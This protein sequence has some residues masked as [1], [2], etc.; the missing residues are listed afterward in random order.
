MLS[1]VKRET[2]RLRAKGW[3]MA[4]AYRAA[5]IKAE[6]AACDSVRLVQE[7]DPEVYDDSYI[8]TWTDTT[9]RQREHYRKETR[10]RILNEGCYGLVGEYLDPA[11]GEWEQADAVWGFIGDDGDDSGY[12]TDIMRSTLDAY[13]KAAD[14]FASNG[15]VELAERGT[16]AAGE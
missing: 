13:R 4:Q 3:T 2:T 12:D 16:Y 10:Q 15:A 8:D 1:Q 9:E 5:K 6:F 7:C 14:A 11:S